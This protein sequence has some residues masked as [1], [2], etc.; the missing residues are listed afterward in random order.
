MQP[1][2]DALGD[3]VRRLYLR[4]EVKIVSTSYPQMSTA[5]AFGV[6]AELHNGAIV[7]FWVDLSS[8]KT[9]WQMEYSVMRHDPDED[10]SHPERDFPAETI[11]SASDLPDRLQAA[12]ESLVNASESPELFR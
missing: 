3:F 10:G 12:I 11:E 9:N 2:R 7:D 1:V 8:N 4:R 5:T 6:S